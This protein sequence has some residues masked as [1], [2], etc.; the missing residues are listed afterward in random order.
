M[1]SRVVECLGGEALTWR[2][3]E[4]YF[5]EIWSHIRLTEEDEMSGLTHPLILRR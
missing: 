1:L 3:G 5:V 4:T 2:T